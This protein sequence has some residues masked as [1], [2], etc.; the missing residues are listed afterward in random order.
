[1]KRQRPF[2]VV[3]LS[4]AF[5]VVSTPCEAESKRI[6]FTAQVAQQTFIGD[7]ASPQLGDQIITNVDLFD[8]S[9]IK[10]GTGA[11]VCTIFSVLPLDTLVECLLTAVFAEGQII[12]GGVAPLA[13]VGASARFGILGGTGDFRKAHGEVIAVVTAPGISDVTFDLD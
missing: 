10:V 7:S 12:F 6:H 4:I 13:E 8:D 5:S 9:D 1:M 3:V 11:G 2:T